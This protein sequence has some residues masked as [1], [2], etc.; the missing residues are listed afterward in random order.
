MD[1]RYQ[2]IDT[3]TGEIKGDADSLF[4]EPMTA[5]G[6]RF[7]SHKLGARMFADVDFPAE[8]SREEIGAMAIIA[9]RCLVG[10]S[11][12]V[13]YR[14]RSEIIAYTASEIAE[15]AGYAKRQGYRFVARMLRLRVV[16]R[17]QSDGQVHF[18]V[19]PAYFMR[20]GQRLSLDLFLLF[21]AELTP[22]LPA[23]IMKLFTQQAQGKAVLKSDAKDE[24]ERIVKH[25][26]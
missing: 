24:A 25:G 9:R 2:I 23:D 21:R 22:L 16:R 5:E 26:T 17:W 1:K 8:M 10:T 4:P 7:P 3:K 15:V 12:M 18:Y 20:S 6:Y 19:N 13:G 11:N 14:H